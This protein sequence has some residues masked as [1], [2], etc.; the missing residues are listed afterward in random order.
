MKKQTQRQ[1]HPAPE[2]SLLTVSIRRVLVAG[3]S[4]GVSNA[5]AGELP[6]PKAAFATLGRADQSIVGNTMT[7]TQHT[8][9]AVLN[10]E[11]FNIGKDNTVEFKQPGATAVALNRIYQSDPSAIFGNL[12]AN[13]Q[14][15]LLNQNGFMFGRD[16][17]VNVNSLVVSSLNMS[18]DTFEKG[19]TKVFNQDGRAALDGNGDAYRKDASNQYVLNERGEK[20][21]TRIEFEAGAS[22]DVAQSGRLIIA[23]PSV[24][25]SG[26]LKAPK[27]QI[28][29]VASTDKVYLQETSNDSSLR[30]LVVEV[31]T[32]GDVTNLG[33]MISDSGNTTL[34]GFAVNQQGRISATT[35]VSA[36]GSIRLLAREGAAVRRE[37]DKWVLQSS[38][39]RRDQELGD[40][41]GT[42]ANVT[43]GTGSLTQATPNL[44][45]KAKAVDSQVQELSRI[46]VMGKD[47]VM[48]SGAVIR[49]NAGQVTMSATE[50]PVSP[51]QPNVKNDSQL[52]IAA[53]AVIDVSGIKNVMVPVERNVV[54]IELR[55]NELRDAPLQ[56]SGVLYGKKIKVDIRKGTP[57]ADISGAL[58]RISRTVA[59]RS[60]NGG[61]LNLASEGE[62]GLAEGSRL[63]FSGGSI[64]Y[65]PGRVDTTQLIGPDGRS[66]VDIADANPDVMYL[67]IVQPITK[68]FANSNLSITNPLVGPLGRKE[69]GYIEGKSAGTLN[70][71]TALL[72][73]KSEMLATV[74]NGPNQREADQQAVGG[75]LSIDLARTQTSTQS[76][77]FGKQIRDNDLE[78]DGEKLASAGLQSVK[79]KTNASIDVAAGNTVRLVNGGQLS[80]KAGEIN[81]DGNIVARSGS[82]DLQTH[83]VGGETS[84]TGAID[85]AEGSVIDTSGVWTNDRAAHS[86]QQ[87][88]MDY[89]TLYRDGGTV[90]IKAEGDVNVGAGSL[91]DVSGGAQRLAS[92]V[93]RAG[94]AGKIAIVAAAIDGSD[95]S[96][97]GQLAG[98]AI[99]GGKGG[100]LSLVSDQVVLGGLS[101]TAA[102]LGSKPLI[103]GSGFFTTG[104]FERYQIGSNKSGIQ[105]ADNAKIRLSV[106]NRLLDETAAGHQS[107]DNL[108]NF[109]H[110]ETLPE[111]GRPAGQLDLILSQEVGFGGNQ[112]AITL[113]EGS[114]LSTSPGGKL[115]L[116]SDGSI[117]ANGSLVAKSGEVA[118]T[119]LPPAQT[120]P[121]FLPNQ[122]IWLG[123]SARVDVGGTS[124]TYEDGRLGTVGQVLDGGKITLRADRGFI[125]TQQGS[126]MNVAGVADYLTIPQRQSNLGDVTRAQQL[127]AS[128]GGTIELLAADGM[129]I[130]G[131]MEAQG[132]GEGA[133]GGQLLVEM[134][135]YTRNEPGQIVP[136]QLP[137]PTVPSVIS[138]S[139][140]GSGGAMVAQGGDIAEQNYGYSYLSADEIGR[141]GFSALTFKTPHSIEFNS[142]VD[143]TANRRLVFDASVL[144]WN[145]LG[146]EEGGVTLK[147]PYIALGSTQTR[148]G[149]VRASTGT[150]ILNVKA[151]LVD[152][153][154][155]AATQGFGITQLESTGDMRLVGVRTKQQQRD[156]LGE[157]LTGGDIT[158]SANQLYPTTLSDFRVAIQGNDAGSIT[159]ARTGSANGGALLS[160]GGKL[161]LDAPNI[162]QSGTIRAPLGEI[163]LKATNQL[164]LMDGSITSNSAAGSLIPFGKVQ[165]GLDWIYA[166]GQQSL[167]YE[168]PPEKRLTL[169][170]DNVTIAA[171]AEIDT[172]GGG[173]LTAYE[174]IPGLGGSHDVL[175]PASK[176]YNGSFAVMPA[177]RSMAAP[178]DPLEL[179]GS[180]LTVGDSIYLAGGGGLAAGNYVLLPAHYALLPG[181]FL[182]TPKANTTDLLPGRK[183]TTANGGSLVAGYRAVA[184]TDLREARWSGFV[185]ESGTLVRQRSEFSQYTADAF[186]ARKAK[187]NGTPLPYLPRDAGSLAVAAKTGLKLDG[188]IRASAAQGG[189]GGRLDI[190]ADNIAV[191]GQLEAEVVDGTVN[192]L[193][194]KL[195]SLDVAS[196]FIGG[197]RTAGD[198]ATRFEVK[199]NN[200]SLLAGAHLKGQEVILAAKKEVI[201]ANGSSLSS[202]GAKNAID[203]NMPIYEVSGDAAFVR[204]SKNQQ[205]DL[206][207]T[208]VRGG[209]GSINLAAGAKIS[210]SGSLMLDATAENILAGE[211]LASGGS[212]ALGAKRIS[213]GEVAAE[214]ASGL[215]LGQ[216]Q[217]AAIQ[218][219]DLILNSG[220]DISFFGSVE[221]NAKNLTL[222]SG[223]LLGFANAGKT[224]TLAA[225]DLRIVN[226]AN[227]YTNMHG[228]GTGDLNI[229]AQNLTLGQG[230]YQLGGFRTANFDISKSLT[231]DQAGSLTARADLIIRTPRISGGRG[232]NT[233]IDATG[234]TVDLRNGGAAPEAAV[235]SLGARLAITADSI[236]QG[237]QLVF[238]SGSVKLNALKGNLTLVQGAEID[239]SGQSAVL[240]KTTIETSGGVIQLQADSGNVAVDAGARLKLGGAEGGTLAISVP[241]GQISLAGTMDA[242]GTQSGGRFMLD[243]GDTHSIGALGALGSSLKTSGFTDQISLR[244]RSGDWSL[245]A[246]DSV[247]ARNIALV[248]DQGAINL[249]GQITARGQGA[250]VRLNAADELRLASS[251]RLVV[252]GSAD[253]GGLLV[254]SA[255]DTDGDG[256]GGITLDR[257]AQVDVHDQA[258]GATGEVRLRVDR[259]GQDVAFTGNITNA[260][261]GSENTT[262]EAVKT[263][264]KNGA[265]SEQDIAGWKSETD[266]YMGN[267]ATIESRLGLPGGLLAGLDIRSKGDLTVDAS[268]W[269]LVDWRYGG[270][271]GVL[272]LTA[273]GNIN[274][275][276]KL[277]DGFK[278]DPKGIDLTANGGTTVAV[279]DKLQT[280]QSWGFHLDAGRS[281]H[282]A[283]NSLI[284]TGTGNIDVSAGEDVV[285]TNATSAIYTAGRAD[286]NRYGSLK[287]GFVA[288]NFYGEY[289]VEGGDISIT[290][291]RDVV[292]ARTG[293]LF[294]GW[295]VRTGNWTQNA[296]HTG[297]TP[298]AW[299]VAIGGPEGTSRPKSSFNQNI[300]ALGGGNIVVN[301]GRDVADLSA[302]IATTGKQV[303]EARNP[304][305]P[306][307]NN[308]N[309]NVVEVLGG[310]NLSVNAGGDVLGGTF[311]TGRGIADIRASGSIKASETG[312]NLGPVLALGDSQFKLRA[313]DDIELAAVIN[314][315]VI[316]DARSKN[317]FFTYTGDSSISLQALSGNVTL[318]NRTVELID[319]L[320]A[321]RPGNNQLRFPGVSQ[322]ALTVYPAGFNAVALQGDVIFGQSL[323][324]YPGAKSD[325]IVMAGG[326]ITTG[327]T[328]TNV[329]ITLSDADAGLLPG[330]ANPASSWEDASQRLQP[331]GNS[332]FIHAKV[333]VH[334][335]D[336]QPALIYAKGDIRSNDALLF[337][338]AKAAEVQ[339]GRDIKDVSFQIQ[340]ADYGQ[341]N[342]TAGRDIQFTTPRNAQGN[343]VNLTREIRV[344]GPGELW[345]TAGRTIDLGASAGAYTIGNTNNTALAERG[346]SISVQAGV[347]KGAD[348]AGFAKKYDPASSVYAKLLTSYMGERTGATLTPAEAATAYKALPEEQQHEFL[349]KILFQEIQ[350]AASLAA[351]NGK[352]SDYNGGYAAI[353]TL[354]PGA[355]KGDDYIGD[356]KLFFSR[357]HTVDGGDINMMVPGG[358][359]N[360]GLAV[361]FAGAKPASE[362]GIVAQ[363]E[364]GI[365]GFVD[366]NFLVNQSRVFALDGGNI[367]LW[368]SNGNIDAGRGSKASI[369]VPPPIIS[370]DEQGNLKVEVPPAVSGSGIRTAASTVV[371]PGDVTLAA[372]RGVV[373]AGEAGIGGSNITIAATAVIG[374]SNIDVGGSSSGVPS[375]SVSVPIASPG[376][377]S[378]AASA[379]NQA[380]QTAESA[381]NNDTNQA[382]EKNQLADNASG[383][384]PLQVD[385][386]G[387]G[388]CAVA[389][390]KEGKPGCV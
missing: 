110:T 289:P 31:A 313:G 73:L 63:D 114:E 15:Y 95:L 186:Y 51:V 366:G 376:A 89:S 305:D 209:T 274:I 361:A 290:A 343:L 300:G 9:Q 315:T 261:N 281:V 59:E 371:R 64:F 69:A 327:Q 239:V 238:P 207:R 342:I 309:T 139:A 125:E 387:F 134:N 165:G 143:L 112:A 347:A 267:A 116:T 128:N 297:E 66:V 286:A 225:D 255:V 23:A 275:K 276:G 346:A 296:D 191:V 121:G 50:N 217:L 232:A 72:N 141:S 326:N 182:V 78:L 339:A 169:S 100:T 213:L 227:A 199:A 21:K 322:E 109:T 364:G 273:L 244:G 333:P 224:A 76:V 111:L 7:I 247:E 45:D 162:F 344:A 28:L 136:G 131:G 148:P 249:A 43:L 157:F 142:G 294:D 97:Q 379:S 352:A 303:G 172:R 235:A 12:K 189:Q 103:L 325:F 177:Y 336:T 99:A 337:S 383:F 173:D 306:T 2:L 192:L 321:I 193:A 37:G 11:K 138:I 133:Q 323:V 71:Q 84:Q 113:G 153:V 85:L 314:P 271:A 330:I 210:S 62:T 57:L 237:S 316:N 27:G 369:A 287:N 150:G 160:A 384:T 80:L 226:N 90:L 183:L 105:V 368:S 228:Y 170:G 292:G 230:D 147:A 135:P 22:V 279:T 250:E 107:G 167:V 4:L 18:D 338:I 308:F 307:G 301:A 324:T 32:G 67:G 291:G 312:D 48:E 332:N 349:L 82:V 319:S 258:G 163:T 44:A 269:D 86:N 54:E 245:N 161:T 202:D 284:R 56:K 164:S 197:L 187:E 257:G 357:I 223:G 68:L 154:G 198:E 360:A 92:G 266:S 47:I 132:G 87:D 65:K 219:S 283:A 374:A 185:V 46:E 33:N 317:Y 243:A 240:G 388:E 49:A 159:V 137:F 156:L 236:Q 375:T 356:L 115:T 91:I 260:V 253:Q 285:L 264:Q 88:V 35:S 6:I 272:S 122:G 310:G 94:D 256:Q 25:N 77:V 96:M 120:D 26:T 302:V 140:N 348:W 328:G 252:Q 372:P 29:A 295:M 194:D 129:N 242:K 52:K 355:G 144:N 40:G 354:Y 350:S 17:K 58:D 171:G 329:N 215:L 53:G 345:L 205:A 149:S 216:E 204:V 363:R 123:S 146:A 263:Y 362:L 166:L 353:E 351:K 93:I 299:A 370:F 265:I 241:K 75:T 331:F 200:I 155:T 229:K 41:L 81:V 39:T 206:Q 378:A 60:T 176:G 208:N 145:P 188:N 158:L 251:S 152:L 124:Q 151:G 277:T 359:V 231:G 385:V 14:V 288:N 259:S 268:G 20:I 220:S 246:G 278:D 74:V 254:A 380:T 174:F 222:R 98:Y 126:V 79:I 341:T 218:A 24:V 320:N 304:N 298:T 108:R 365:N 382:M 36:N 178:V 190:A 390:I 3:I 318:A 168:K 373:D 70:I 377:A 16:S 201:L 5:E 270:R 334:Q 34:M 101:E 10:W 358:L 311:Y 367:T 196:I 233:S 117:L 83:L 212:V 184:G 102:E 234:Y 19:F 381:V 386:L 195:N 181:A 175:D 340:H 293:Q 118:M 262:V 1:T 335:G 61:T 106:Q 127:I 282:I 389:D 38:R 203:Q 8:K 214:G 30:G 104:G 42:R 248:A 179:P 119:I 130:Q 180:G 211:L 280:G 13:G 221:L 55:S